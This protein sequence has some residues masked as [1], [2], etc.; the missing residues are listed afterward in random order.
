[1]FNNKIQVV[2]GSANK[3]KIKAAKEAFKKFCS[4]LT[5]LGVK[6]DSKVSIQPISIEEAYRGALNRAKNALKIYPNADFGVGIEGTLQKYDC[7][8]ATCGVVV[9]Y[10]QKKQIGLGI[11]P[12]LFLPKKIVEKISQHQELG[13]V[14]KE[15]SQGKYTKHQGGAF[16]FFTDNLITRQ[17]GYEQAI[18]FALSRFSKAKLWQ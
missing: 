6:A 7:G 3:V 15:I 13:N 9:I 1:M 18:T 4:Q 11:S 16:G 2:V 5:V 14:I 8:W 17:E 10:N 12:Q